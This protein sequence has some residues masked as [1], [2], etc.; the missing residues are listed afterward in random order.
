[1]IP[2]RRTIAAAAY[3]IDL[4]RGF[5]RRIV[6]NPRETPLSKRPIAALGGI[7]GR[8]SL[9]PRRAVMLADQPTSTRPPIR[10][11]IELAICGNRFEALLKTKSVISHPICQTQA[12][13]V[14][15][16][17]WTSLPDSPRFIPGKSVT[18]LSS[19]CTALKRPTVHSFLLFSGPASSFS[20]NRRATLSLYYQQAAIIR[21]P[22][23]F[24]P[25][26][27]K[28]AKYGPKRYG[29]AA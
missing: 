19:L 16:S 5:R 4:V 24:C 1:M 18:G 14:V 27:R 22:G 23:Q 2:S 28:A 20:K 3:P 8:V 21:F 15:G 12:L 6:K 7:A 9:N 11:T 10:I 25:L 29:V 26:G 13:R 17:A